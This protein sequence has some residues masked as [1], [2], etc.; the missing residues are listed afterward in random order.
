MRIAHYCAHA[1]AGESGVANSARG[2]AGAQAD[3]G[4]AVVLVVDADAV[5]MPA[6]LG[7]EVR[8]VPHVA[9]LGVPRPRELA[10]ALHGAEVV[11]PHGG[12]APGLNVASVVAGR[13]G[14]ATIPLTHGVYYP[15]A[16]DRHRLRKQ[17]WNLVAERRTLRRAAALHLLFREEQEGLQ[18]LGVRRPL[19]VATNGIDAPAGITWRGG[20]DDHL[21]YLGRYDPVHKGLDHLLR[22]L[23]H[24]PPDARPRLRM[25]GP[26]WHGGRDHVRTL[27]EELGLG[28]WVHVG[29]AVAADAKWDLL[30]SS[31]ALVLTSRWEAAPMGLAEAAAIGVPALVTDYPMGRWLADRDAAVLATRDPAG[32][33]DGLTAITGPDAAAIGAR[34]REVARTELSWQAVTDTWARQVGALGLR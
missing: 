15:A 30:A 3:A 9:R 8:P 13:V 25:H 10:G 5:R 11:V 4:H 12:W 7:V 34:A 6:P 33:A 22:G 14:A 24:L 23:A 21:L 20:S 1:L 29:D 18:R 16:L 26:D 2:W 19:V 32:I 17:A 31:R 27:V 28:G